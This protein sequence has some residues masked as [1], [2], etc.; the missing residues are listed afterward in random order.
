[1]LGTAALGHK[2]AAG[3]A[4]FLPCNDGAGA[5]CFQGSV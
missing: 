3:N 4:A 1:M 5:A 2:G